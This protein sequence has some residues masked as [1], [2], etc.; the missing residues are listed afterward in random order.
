MTFRAIGNHPGGLLPIDQFDTLD[1]SLLGLRVQAVDSATSGYGYGEFI[2]LKGI[3]STAVG[4]WVVF[5]ADDW[6][7]V[8]LDTDETAPVDIGPCAIAMSANIVA[9]TGGWYQIYG[10]ASGL[11][12]ASFADNGDVYA[13]ST[14]G[15]VDDAVVDGFM[16]HNARGAST[17]VGAGL[18]DFEI[19][20]PYTDGIAAND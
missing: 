10:K 16:V 7:T 5:T 20:Y 19:Y 9:T 17:I 18:A 11:A 3:A 8:L 6:S 4:S 1:S 12:L 15:S 13:T 14:G 2:Y